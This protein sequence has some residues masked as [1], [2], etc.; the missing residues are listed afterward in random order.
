[1]SV[2]FEAA[3]SPGKEVEIR[4]ARVEEAQ[5]LSDLSYRSKAH[6]PYDKE[7]LAQCKAVTHVTADDVRE[8]PFRVAEINGAV[9]GFS[10][11]CLVKDEA[12]LDHLWIEPEFI[13]QG[14]G[15]RLFDV[16]VGD[17]REL[18]WNGFTIAADPYAEDFYR[19]MGAIRIGERE[20]KVKRGF[21]LPLLQYSI[22]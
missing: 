9:V 3:V 21:F 13:G 6:W 19:K 14:V 8:W 7:Y 2:C 10:A 22:T 1:M 4:R 18:G 20:S 16:S 5:A 11:V 17:A 12:M 15:R